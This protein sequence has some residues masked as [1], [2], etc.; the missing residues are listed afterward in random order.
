MIFWLPLAI[1]TVCYI[2]IVVHVVIHLN[3]PTVKEARGGST[4]SHAPEIAEEP[5]TEVTYR[6]RRMSRIPSLF[7]SPTRRHLLVLRLLALR[8]RLK[9]GRLTRALC[10]QTLIVLT[11]YI[12]LWLPYNALTLWAYLSPEIYIPHRTTI[13]FLQELIVV[14]SVINPF[15][16][17]CD[18]YHQIVHERSRRDNRGCACSV[19]LC[20]C[21]LAEDSD[22]SQQFL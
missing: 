17:A 3:E 6:R 8:G 2:V 19:V 10:R 22:V 21:T 11:A 20:P 14:N 15:L 16:Y 9:C 4:R 7:L 1:I 18:V 5:S 12:V 13:R